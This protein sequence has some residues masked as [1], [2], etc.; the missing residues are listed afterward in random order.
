MHLE[1]EASLLFVS[2][3]CWHSPQMAL[4]LLCW[5]NSEVSQLIDRLSD[6]EAQRL[7]T[8]LSS[9]IQLLLEEEVIRWD[10]ELHNSG[11][12]RGLDPSLK[13]QGSGIITIIS[14]SAKET[15]ILII[16]ILNI[17][18]LYIAYV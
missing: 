17:N 12:G 8:T 5:E 13:K 7:A 2:Y 10:N 14:L 16:N 9:I 11:L 4:P 6:F 3:L 1:I 15:N 18:I